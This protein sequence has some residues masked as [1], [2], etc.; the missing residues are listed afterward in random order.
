M[1]KLRGK[2][3]IITGG[4]GGIG[5]ATAE[6]FIEEGANVLIFDLNESD[7]IKSCKDIGS[8]NLSYFVGDVTKYEDNIKASNDVS[9]I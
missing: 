5:K 4:S 1:N 9:P 7:L 8:N 6:A 3:A 2:V